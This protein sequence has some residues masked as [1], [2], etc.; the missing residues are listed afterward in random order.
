MNSMEHSASAA[1]S[2]Q[3]EDEISLLDLALVAAENLRLLV[4]GPLLAGLS[5]LGI[6]FLVPPTFTAKAV[7]M[8][9]QQQQSSA[10][11]ALQS[12]GA[13]AGLAGGA[14]G[15]KS[16]ADQYVALMQSTTV[17]DRLIEQFKLMQVY[18]EKWK[19]DTRKE[20][21]GN[22]RISSGKKDGLIT[23]EVD[24]RDP[25]RAA[26]IAN[27]YIEELR[28]V[29][30]RLAMTEAQQRRMFFEKQLGQTKERFTA[31]QQALQASGINEGA[32]RA[33]PKAA[34]EAYARLRAEV[35]AAEV[36]LQAMRSYLTEAAPEFQM[37]QNQ[38]AALRA[39]MAKAEGSNSAAA[40]SDYISRFREFKYQEALF[41]LFAKQYELARVDESREGALIQVVDPATPPERKS[42][43]KKA[44]IAVVATLAAGFALL[45][46]VFVRHALRSARQG[47]DSA[48]KLGMLSAALRRSVGRGA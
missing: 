43:P 31:A 30:T 32:I 47:A 24:D 22:T 7:M 45:L 18:D 40:Q 23:I 4:L 46:W 19:A 41:E 14:A 36:R 37:A 44:M 8:P 6:S 25:Q 1:P 16:P 27:A 34:A 29:T 28:L 17:E 42:K 12:L 20:L 9:P 2:E 21:E 39:Q 5:A 26:A 33:E 38:L 3:A 10:A 11:A 35:T 13:L 15:I 48:Q